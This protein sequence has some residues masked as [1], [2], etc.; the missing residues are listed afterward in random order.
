LLWL[1]L[2][3]LL[4]LLLDLKYD[5]SIRSKLHNINSE[6]NANFEPNQQPTYDWKRTLNR[7]GNRYFIEL[8][9]KVMLRPEFEMHNLLSLLSCGCV[10]PKVPVRDN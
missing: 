1:L 2:L 10:A 5:T 8:V 7:A 3:L 4:L 6:I 9:E